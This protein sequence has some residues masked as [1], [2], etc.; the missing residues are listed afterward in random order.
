M[1]KEITNSVEALE[2]EAE[3]IL[4]KAKTRASEIFLEARE[5]AKRILS[6]PL[7]LDAVKT[8]Y[9]RIVS[10]ATAEADEKIRDSEKRAAEIGIN[11]DK[12]VKEIT[13]LVVNIVTGRS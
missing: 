10:R 1:A 8:E 7:S 6:S 13:E 9:D 12:K 3:K 11:A 2:V 4:E 5:E